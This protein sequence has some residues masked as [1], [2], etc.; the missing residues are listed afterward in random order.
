[1]IAHLPVDVEQAIITELS[2]RHTIGSSLPAV[3]PAQFI[4]VLAAGGFERDMV[5]DSFIVTL[6]SFATRESTARAQL[7]RAV[8]WLAQKVLDEHTVGG[9]VAY[10]FQLT[11]VPQ[12][13]PNPDVPTH[14]R[15]IAT[16]TLDL[17][18]QSVI[19]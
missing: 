8:A 5:T 11:A 7:A 10:R 6:E 9:A 18:R 16:L 19:L 13:F 12:N 2:P 15:Y 17:R 1:M 3:L 14:K 4:R